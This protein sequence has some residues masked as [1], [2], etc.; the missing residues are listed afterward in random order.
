MIVHRVLT[1]TVIDHCSGQPSTVNESTKT[2]CAL[3]GW[4]ITS[5]GRWSL[6]RERC[7]ASAKGSIVRERDDDRSLAHGGFEP[8]QEKALKVEASLGH[9]STEGGLD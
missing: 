7:G 8:S 2:R 9:L 5:Y 6:P 4:G 1:V 3:F